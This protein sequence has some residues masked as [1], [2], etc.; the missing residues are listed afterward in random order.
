[1]KKFFSSTLACLLLFSIILPAHAAYT[2]NGSTGTVNNQELAQ[3][4][5]KN[6]QKLQ[7]VHAVFTSDNGVKYNLNVYKLDSTTTPQA[8]MSNSADR[9]V[10]V[11]YV[12]TTKDMA[13]ASW[14]PYPGSIMW[15][16]TGSVEFL[17]SNTYKM[18]TVNGLDR[19]L[20][21]NV[22]GTYLIHQSGVTVSKTKF[23]YGCESVIEGIGMQNG[24]KSFNGK[25]NFATNYTKSVLQDSHSLIGSTLYAT[26]SKGS[27]NWNFQFTENKYGGE[28]W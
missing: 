22:A 25:C 6:G 1:M 17:I 27:S 14:P 8:L 4:V 24:E 23:K 28:L 21:T 26:I 2:G 16:D 3:R 12:A 11:T 19:I 13:L 7:D 18:S 15:D 20:L 9:E 5:L 10:T